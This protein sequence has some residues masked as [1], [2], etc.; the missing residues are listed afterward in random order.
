[1]NNDIS[2]K[3][4]LKKLELLRNSKVCFG[5]CSNTSDGKHIIM[6]DYDDISLNDVKNDI[7]AIQK[8]FN[9]SA[10]YVLSSDNGYNAFCLSKKSISEIK[11]IY[12][13]SKHLDPLYIKLSFEKRGYFV[14]RMSGNKKLI[15]TIVTNINKDIISFA[16]YKFFKDIMRFNLL[17]FNHDIYIPYHDNLTTFRIIGYKSVKHGFLECEV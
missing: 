10:F 6:F 12:N 3:E 13:F 1:M 7:I 9:L 4:K 16:H 15:L 5:I 2:L 11:E 14:L 17:E 8:K